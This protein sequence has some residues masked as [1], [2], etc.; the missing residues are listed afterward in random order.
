MTVTRRIRFNKTKTKLLLDISLAV[1]FLAALE[2]SLTGFYWHEWLGIGLGA[3][4]IVHVLL[5]WSWVT[6]V[7]RRF[8]GRTSGQVRLNYVLNLVLLAAMGAVIASGLVISKTLGTAD[9]LGISFQASH[10]WEEIHRWA[11]QVALI[12]VGIHLG[13]HWK[14][15]VSTVQRTVWKPRCRRQTLAQLPRGS[16]RS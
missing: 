9:A 4:F 13:L 2:P 3:A 12:V 11:P 8:F 10:T 7:T 1:A 14:W 5:S 6:S 15:I 16:A